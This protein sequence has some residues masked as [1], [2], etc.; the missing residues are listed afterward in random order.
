MADATHNSRALARTSLV[1][2]TGITPSS[3]RTA[4]VR[5][6]GAQRLRKA[7][8]ILAWTLYGLDGASLAANGRMLTAHSVAEELARAEAMIGRAL[9]LL[10][11]QSAF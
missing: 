5:N 2:V 6:C 10:L 3:G 9:A 1:W 4:P 11:M 8:S 7:T